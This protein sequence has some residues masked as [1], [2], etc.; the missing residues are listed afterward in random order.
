MRVS[1]QTLELSA[2]DL[3]HFLACRHRTA[4]DLAVAQGMRA[5]PSWVDPALVLLQERGLEHERRYVEQLREQGLEGVDLSADS[6]EDA[7]ARATDAMRAGVG[8]IVQPAF[9]I[10][11]WFG[12]PDL[13]RRVETPSA[14]GP[15]SYEV[16]DT[17][18]AK[19][20]RGG[21]IL[22]LV[23]Y[24]ELLLAVQAA[25]PERFHVV[26][27]DPVS[28]VQSYRVQEFAAYFRLVRRRLE[29]TTLQDPGAIAAAN[30]PEPV[31][32]CDVCRWW[33][34][35]DRRRREDDH[36][37]LVAGISHLQ[38]RE[39]EKAGVTTLAGLGTLPLPLP[40]RPRRGAAD[41]YVRVREQARIQLRGRSEGKPVHELLPLVAGPGTQPAACALG[42]GHLPRSR[43]RSVRPRRRPR[44]PVRSC[45][46]HPVAGPCPGQRRLP[47]LQRALGTLGRRGAHG[48][49]RRG[50][51]H[52]GVVA[53]LP[54]NARLPLRSL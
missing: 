27:P 36:L 47:R 20:T 11:R 17:K 35:C 30:Y 6:G 45:G 18:L 22:Q 29:A 37:T 15:W 34:T 21:T 19:E 4:L 50:R 48:V 24:S 3:S 51:P 25:A 42:R 31:A 16:V 12:R 26:T 46:D 28:P 8:L 5:A 39:L 13:L 44:V 41:T 1:T 38:T 53:H 54:G 2:S 52:S 49:R 9:R 43:R 40:F 10:G 14:F 7:V 32:H 23:L 33:S